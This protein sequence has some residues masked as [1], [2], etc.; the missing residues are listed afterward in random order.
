MKKCVL[1]SCIDIV[2]ALLVLCRCIGSI[3]IVLRV[4][5]RIELLIVRLTFSRT[6][7]WKVTEH[8]AM[9]CRGHFLLMAD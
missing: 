5:L 8:T 7:G 4:L 6:R 2:T 1:A 9:S 3:F